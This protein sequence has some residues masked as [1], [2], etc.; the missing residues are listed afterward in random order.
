M[1]SAT[2]SAPRTTA[3]PT[4]EMARSTRAPIRSRSDYRRKVAPAFATIMAYA[5]DEPWLG[6]FSDPTASACGAPCGVAD[7]AD[8]VRSIN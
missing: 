8:N 3:K 2:T 4:S 7:Q 1:K 5:E 6:R